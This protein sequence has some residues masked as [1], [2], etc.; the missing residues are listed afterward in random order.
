MH[1]RPRSLLRHYGL[2]ADVLYWSPQHQRAAE[3]IYDGIDSRRI[4]AVIGQ[5]GAGKTEL[6]RTALDNLDCSYTWLN[7]P[8][9]EGLSAGQVTSCMI[10]ALG[11]E[12][13]RQ[14]GQARTTQL[15]R[16]LG[17]HAVQHNRSV[18][19]VID[20][21]HRMSPRTLLALKDLRESC[22][23]NGEAPLFS[24]ILIGQ[25]ALTYKLGHIGEVQFRT[26]LV[27][28]SEERSWM[29][30]ADRE[31]YLETIYREVITPEARRRLA[32][33]FKR[34]L[35]LDY[36]VELILEQM[37]DAGLPQ[38]SEDLVPMTI[39]EEMKFTG[40]S[41]RDLSKITGVPKSTIQDA[42]TDDGVDPDVMSRLR[43]GM[44]DLR[45]GRV[46]K[47]SKRKVA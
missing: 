42:K 44:A 45:S 39:A 8:D 11:E 24:I 30:Q 26:K 25:P 36:Q 37:R 7:N 34:P 27:E 22:M 41:L 46:E 43:Q 5:F 13:P 21:A 10:S 29:G 35:T 38:M 2:D 40:V 18:V 6:V 4:I 32:I 28:L 31:S 15:A 9:K 1:N 3:Q 33:K 19:I 17:H 20:N 14:D 16:I 12:K 47:P 23:F